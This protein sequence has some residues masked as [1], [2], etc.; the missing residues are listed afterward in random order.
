MEKEGPDR[1]NWLPP[2][3]PPFQIPMNRVFFANISYLISQ[4]E[5]LMVRIS[6]E[7][8][9]STQSFLYTY[10]IIILTTKFLEGNGITKMQLVS[11][12][13]PMQDKI[14]FAQ[15]GLC[16]I[17]FP[18]PSI[19]FLSSPH[20]SFSHFLLFI[21]GCI[22]FHNLYKRP[23]FTLISFLLEIH[24]STCVPLLLSIDNVKKYDINFSLPFPS[25]RLFVAFFVIFF[26]HICLSILCYIS[27]IAHT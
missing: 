6:I 10:S 9:E 11:S 21:W 7:Y 16:L 25:F 23:Y 26:F 18:L 8:W 14:H 1:L 20:F 5:Q 2:L 13:S 4:H 3:P 15:F 24:T 12:I 19:L 17:S 27:S 22:T